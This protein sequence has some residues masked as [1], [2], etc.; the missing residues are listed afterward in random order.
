VNF[1]D[2]ATSFQGQ[3]RLL[4][5]AVALSGLLAL[6]IAAMAWALLDKERVVVLVPPQ[7]AEETAISADGASED[8]LRS[9]GMFVADRIGN[10]TPAN[11]QYT[12]AALEPLLAPAIYDEVIARL[13]TEIEKVRR[14]RLSRSFE[15]H[16][17]L[18]EPARN[19]VFVNGLMVTGT[20][21][22]A[23]TRTTVTIEIEMTVRG[24]RPRIAYITSY[25]GQPRTREV[26][27]RMAMEANQ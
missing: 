1:R 17:V 5:L 24:Y 26:L 27:D 13:E 4:F 7:L 25:E 8:Y 6:A 12:R 9:W 10:V 22:G 11:V 19:R 21:V 3:Q 15:P 16:Q 23:Q 2:Y 14:D 20:L 18:L